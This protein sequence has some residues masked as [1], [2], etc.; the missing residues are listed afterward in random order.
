[1]QSSYID[2]AGNMMDVAMVKRKVN[3]DNIANMNTPDFKASKVM[4]EEL[5]QD[6]ENQL[7]LKGDNKKH[8]AIGSTISQDPMIQ[9]DTSKSERPDGNN[10]DLTQEMLE[11]IKINGMQNKAIKAVNHEFDLI[12][13]AIGF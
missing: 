12:R 3:A 7:A 4:F 6:T 11:T 10:V 1:M 5:L 13:T 2:F 9:T 8:I